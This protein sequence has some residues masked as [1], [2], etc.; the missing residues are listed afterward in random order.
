MIILA[1]GAARMSARELK[2]EIEAADREIKETYHKKKDKSRN[3]LMDN[4]SPEMA[5]LLEKMRLDD[6]N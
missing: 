5:E 4:L 1:G 6:K 3:S 2:R